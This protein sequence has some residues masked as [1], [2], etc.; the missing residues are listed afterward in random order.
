[1]ADQRVEGEELKKLVKLGKKKRLSF[2]FCPGKKNDHTILIDRRKPPEVIAKIAKKEGDGSKVAFG[3]FEVKSKTMELTCDR[4]VPAL[5]KVLKKYLKSQKVQVNILVMD[6]SGNVLESDIEDLPDDP[7]WDAD[8]ADAAEADEAGAQDAAGTAAAAAPQETA[9]QKE[10]PQ[11]AAP[12]GGPAQADLV[13]RLKAVQPAVAAAPAAVADKLKKAAAQAV[14]QIKSGDL[15]A[16]DRTVS[17][18]E[19]AADRLQG[20]QIG[21]EPPAPETPAEPPA[22]PSAAPSAEPST[23]TQSDPGDTAADTRRLAARAGALKGVISGLPDPAGGKLIAALTRVVKLLKAGDLA[24]AGDLLNRIEAAVNQTQTAPPPQAPQPAETETAEAADPQQAKWQMAQTRLQ[25]AI[26]R[27]IAEKRGDLAAINR[28]FGYAQEQAEAGN[29][30]KALAAAGRVAALI[31]AA[32]TAETTAAAAEAQAAAP[33]NVTA[34]TRSRL[35]WIKTR[36]A[37]RSDLEAL[38]K[39]IDAA[40]AGVEGMEDVPARSGVLF[41]YL[42]DID[43]SLEDTLEQLV[44]TPD[45]D[46]REGLKTAAR[47]IIDDYRGL[48][49]TE[50]FKAVDDNGFARTSIRAGALAALQEVSGALA[51]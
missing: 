38:K 15:A 33:E 42:D 36:Q 11:D 30:D 40:T 13:A 20:A 16:A 32:A 51:S 19:K 43:S 8:E 26:D 45:G 18:L 17:A 31:K 35:N 22:Q 29:Y 2:A 23:Q 41:D 28:F 25:P 44:E 47:R 10:A 7:A 21:A 3:T 9:D 5:A 4:V 49:D 46:R 34:Y 14:A 39:A 50:F 12:P 27:L 1:M 48:L 37:L 6:A 24:A